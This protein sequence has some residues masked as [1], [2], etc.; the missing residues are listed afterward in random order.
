MR[1][2]PLS[3]PGQCLSL[4]GGSGAADGTQLVLAACSAAPEQLFIPP[5]PGDTM[6]VMV[7]NTAWNKTLSVLRSG[8]NNGAAVGVGPLPGLAV[9]LRWLS[10]LSRG[11]FTGPCS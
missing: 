4:P 10:T 3:D 11:Y 1:L 5:P 8:T 9:P 7:G 6:Y 2:E